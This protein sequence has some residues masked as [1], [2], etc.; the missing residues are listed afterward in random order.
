[1]TGMTHLNAAERLTGIQVF[2]VV[3]V[4]VGEAGGAHARVMD[5]VNH[6]CHPW[7]ITQYPSGVYGA[8]LVSGVVGQQM[9]KPGKVIL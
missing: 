1:M 7:I 3:C 6:A 4:G 8:N 5:A 2:P 9:R